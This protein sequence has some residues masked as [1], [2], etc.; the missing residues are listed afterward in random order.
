MAGKWSIKL[1]RR[2]VAPRP[3]FGRGR[4]KT[5]FAHPPRGWGGAKTPSVEAGWPTYKAIVWIGEKRL[6]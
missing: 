4:I 1:R 6:P 5:L 3:L 2:E